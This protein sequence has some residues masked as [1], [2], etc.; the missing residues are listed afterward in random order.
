MKTSL[1][2][3]VKQWFQS[4]LDNSLIRTVDDSSLDTDDE[5]TEDGFSYEIIDFSEAIDEIYE[6]VVNS[7][8]FNILKK[9]S[10]DFYETSLEIIVG[11]WS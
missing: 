9:R 11:N 4:N 6:N 3:E 2:K 7:P 5:E 10:A 1:E 8:N